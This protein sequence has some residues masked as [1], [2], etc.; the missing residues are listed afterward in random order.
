MY[1]L[2]LLDFDPGSQQYSDITVTDNGDMPQV[3]A[4]V[5]EVVRIFLEANPDKA[6]YFEG[7]TLAKTRL[8][9]IAISRVYNELE[10][11][12]VVYGMKD[13]IWHRYEPNI[14]F[15]SFLVEKKS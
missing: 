2:A 9:Q 1:N 4:T 14:S 11:D 10:S 15:E 5:I 6:L 12:L 7:N 13:S 8:Y 3:L